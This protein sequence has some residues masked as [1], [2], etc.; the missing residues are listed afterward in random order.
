MDTATKTSPEPLKMRANRKVVE[1]RCAICDRGFE[2]AEEVYACP[3]CGGYHHVPCWDANLSCTA[4]GAAA[5]SGEPSSVMVAPEAATPDLP[6]LAAGERQCPACSMVIKQDALKCR[7]CGTIFDLKLAAGIAPVEM[8]SDL[9]AEAEKIAKSSLTY[10]LVGLIFFSLILETI[11]I[12][13]GAKAL[14]ILRDY[15]QHTTSARGKARA[16][17]VIG[18]IRLSLVVIILL[19]AISS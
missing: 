19:I 9:A 6:T 4:S 1:A 12:F 18:L 13:K 8:P 5:D 3:F 14:K 7:Y 10:A 2:L 11:A 16:G 17:I 15:P